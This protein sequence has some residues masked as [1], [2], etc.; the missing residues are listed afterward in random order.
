MPCMEAGS[1]EESREMGIMLI[2][3]TGKCME[4][5]VVGVVLTW[6]LIVDE[7]DRFHF[8]SGTMQP[9]MGRAMYLRWSGVDADNNMLARAENKIDQVLQSV[10]QRLSKVPYLAGEAF[11]LAD[12]MCVFSFTGMRE[13]TQQD[14]SKYENLLGYLE[15]VTKREG[16]RRAMEKGDPDIDV[17]TLI[18]G[19]P[20]PVFKGLRQRL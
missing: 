1:W 17:S 13:F 10:D 9:A 8:A 4:V 2:F 15:R 18:K 12:I 19:P 14:L 5:I 7:I 3:F 6:S 20:P 11:T 16:Y